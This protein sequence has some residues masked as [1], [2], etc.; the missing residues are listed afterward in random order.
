MDS[1]GS[2]AGIVGVA[3]AALVAGTSPSTAARPVEGPPTG[4]TE[5][6]SRVIN[7]LAAHAA[8]AAG[9][10][11]FGFVDHKGIL[12]AQWRSD[13]VG[14]A[15]DADAGL[16]HELGSIG[17]ADVALAGA[18]ARHLGIAF[19]P[20]LPESEVISHL[21]AAIVLSDLEPLLPP[22][23]LGQV[24]RFDFQFVEHGV[25]FSI[26]GEDGQSRS[27]E[28][29][30][31]D[32][33]DGQRQSVLARTRM[34]RPGVSDDALAPSASVSEGCCEMDHGQSRLVEVNGK[35]RAVIHLYEE[36][37]THAIAVGLVD[38]HIGTVPI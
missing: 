4:H 15:Q 2:V 1:G 12:Y 30:R 10:G 34:P 35:L 21:E 38:C 11:V 19:V 22:D 24:E 13:G 8:R 37:A 33:I 28:G 27:P 7:L 6:G 32:V 26:R 17:D 5:T 36:D 29:E 9:H 20:P 25:P 18:V 31:N 23:D 14:D 3:V 16:L